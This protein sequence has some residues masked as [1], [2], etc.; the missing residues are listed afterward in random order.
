MQSN[1][2]GSQQVIKAAGTVRR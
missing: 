1:Q 2:T